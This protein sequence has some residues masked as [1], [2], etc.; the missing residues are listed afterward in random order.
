MGKSARRR[1]VAAE[2]DLPEW[3]SSHFEYET[4][5]VKSSRRE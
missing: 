4:L 2:E 5:F 1:A 3:R